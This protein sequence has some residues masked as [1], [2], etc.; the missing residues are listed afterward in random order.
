MAFER[1][2][3]VTAAAGLMTADGSHAGTEG[4]F[5]GGLGGGGGSAGGGKEVSAGG[6]AGADGF[7][8]HDGG[9]VGSGACEGCR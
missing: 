7:S 5:G 6:F 1:E 9:I 3:A 8:G 4:G 2:S